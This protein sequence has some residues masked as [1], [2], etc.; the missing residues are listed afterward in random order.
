MVDGIELYYEVHHPTKKR[1]VRHLNSQYIAYKKKP[2]VLSSE[3]LTIPL[4]LPLD[5]VM[6]NNER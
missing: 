4:D 6:S 2:L 5:K 1:T 3:E